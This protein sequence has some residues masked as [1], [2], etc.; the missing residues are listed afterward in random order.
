MLLY[1][2]AGNIG[3]LTI[4][5]PSEGRPIPTRGRCRNCVSDRAI[6]ITRSFRG[7]P[8]SCGRTIQPPA[9]KSRV[10]S[11]NSE[12]WGIGNIVICREQVAV[13]NGG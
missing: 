10:S 3:I 13:P 12:C 7:N 1:E 8:A 2:K 4:T 11:W 5:R 6:S 9:E